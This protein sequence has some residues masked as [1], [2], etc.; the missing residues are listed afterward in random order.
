MVAPALVSFYNVRHGLVNKD[1][2]KFGRIK[3]VHALCKSPNHQRCESPRGLIVCFDR[4]LGHTL[5]EINSINRKVWPVPYIHEFDLVVF[6]ESLTM[7]RTI[8]FGHF[9]RNAGKIHSSQTRDFDHMA[10]LRPD[11]C[12]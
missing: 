10:V 12:P 2:F 8:L 1:P 3:F 5:G 9:P 6:N 4:R 11:I 7:V